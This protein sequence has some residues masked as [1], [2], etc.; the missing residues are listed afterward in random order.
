[1]RE[2]LGLNRQ[3]FGPLQ[4]QRIATPSTLEGVKGDKNTHW[5]IKTWK[6]PF[7]L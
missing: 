5:R 2:W 7:V 1:M 4:K 6:L 3:P